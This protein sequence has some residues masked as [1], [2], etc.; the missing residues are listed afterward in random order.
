MSDF[1]NYKGVQLRVAYVDNS[2][3]TGSNDGDTVSGAYWAFPETVSLSANTVYVIRRNPSMFVAR[4]ATCPNN[5]VVIMGMP[6]TSGQLFYKDLSQ[7][8]KTAWGSDSL[9]FVNMCISGSVSNTP[10]KLGTDD[11]YGGY[12]LFNIN[13]ADNLLINQKFGLVHLSGPGAT[14]DNCSF[15]ISGYSIFADTLENI[16][17]WTGLHIGIGDGVTVNNITAVGYGYVSQD[18]GT[19]TNQSSY[20]IPAALFIENYSPNYTSN[21]NI[22]NSTFV[23][24]PNPYNQ[25]WAFGFYGRGGYAASTFKNL[26]FYSKYADTPYGPHSAMMWIDTISQACTLQGISGWGGYDFRQASSSS[27]FDRGIRIT[28]GTAVDQVYYGFRRTSMHTF[29]DIYLYNHAREH[30]SFNGI[31]LV[32]LFNDCTFDN[33]SIISPSAT[34]QYGYNG[35]YMGGYCYHNTFN[36][37]YIDNGSALNQPIYNNVNSFGLNLNYASGY[38]FGKSYLKN[39]II[40][41]CKYAISSYLH[42][43]VENTSVTGCVQLAGDSIQFNTLEVPISGARYSSNGDIF[44]H[45]GSTNDAQFAPTNNVIHIKELVNKSGAAT[46]INYGTALVAVENMSAAGSLN[47]FTGLNDA[48][49]AGSVYLNNYPQTGYWLGQNYWHKFDTSVVQFTTV[50]GVNSGFSLAYTCLTTTNWTGD[51]EQAFIIS[52]PPYTGAEVLMTAPISGRKQYNAVLY[53]ATKYVPS[54]TTSDIWFE[55]EIPDGTNGTAT[56]KISSKFLFNGIETDTSGTSWIGETPLSIYKITL[57]FILDRQESIYSRIYWNKS[58]P[59]GTS[60][61]YIAPRIIIE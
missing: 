22:S 58:L 4:K 38:T 14:V 12:G 34:N 30:G 52:P 13:F 27:V 21:C 11:N 26:K 15:S 28:N 51:V 44:Y 10:F 47:T 7:S 48:Y 41:S 16:T 56:R 8:V 19:Y 37:L 3:N 5:N 60:K 20:T 61:A 36:N 40:K 35:L 46:S 50:N 54:I 2:L 29:K 25:G 23:I 33:I 31:E 6:A 45:I 17:E 24:K 18:G 43:D 53:F 59:G 42:L 39:S 1:I 57:P 32:N 9:P 49:S 55:L